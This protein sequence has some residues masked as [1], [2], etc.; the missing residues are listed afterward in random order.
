MARHSLATNLRDS[1]SHVSQSQPVAEF[2][3]FLQTN[4]TMLVTS[5]QRNTHFD[6]PVSRT[7]DAK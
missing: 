2:Q 7:T 3:D 1:Q 6:Q 4:V 5:G